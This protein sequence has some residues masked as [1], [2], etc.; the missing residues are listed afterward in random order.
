MSDAKMVTEREAVERERAAFGR[1][2]LW[3]AAAPSWFNCTRTEEAANTVAAERYPL[4]TV[5]RLRTLR[6]GTGWLRWNPERPVTGFVNTV[7]AWEIRALDRGGWTPVS[8]QWRVDLAEVVAVADLKANPY[9]DVP[10]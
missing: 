2:A 4:P 9:E 5:R 10:E 8:D 7:G 3:Y 6:S 1:G